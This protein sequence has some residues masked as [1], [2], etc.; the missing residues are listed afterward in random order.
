M[1]K[2]KIFMDSKNS[3]SKK[4]QNFLSP[5]LKCTVALPTNKPCL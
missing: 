1:R 4:P 2:P 3:G 5:V